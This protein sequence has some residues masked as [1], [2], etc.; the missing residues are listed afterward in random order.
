MFETLSNI[1]RISDLRRRIFYTL[2]ILVVF[3]IGCFI[4]AP[5]I[6]VDLLNFESNNIFGFL[7]VFGGGALENFSIFAMG[8]YPYITAS[9][10]VQLL[11]MDV[12]P[13]FAEWAKQ[14]QEGRRKLAQFT[15]YFTIVLGLIQ[16]FGMT[17]GFNRV[18]PGL[19][20]NPGFGTYLLIVLTLTAG[21]ALLMWMGEQINE[22]GI[23][24]GISIII[25]GGIVAGLPNAA[26]AIYASEFF[27]ASDQWFLNL[28]KVLAILLVV[29]AIIVGVI[30]VQ[31]GIRRIPVQYAKRV[32]GRRMYGGQMTHLPIRVNAAGVI[33]VIFAMALLIF[34]STIASF[35]QGHAVA[36]WII[37]HFNYNRPLG[38]FLYVLLIIGFTYFYTF[39]QIN[40]SQLA[41]NLKKNGGY[42]PGVRPGKATEAYV[43]GVLN[44]ITLTGALFLAAVAILPVFFTAVTNLPQTVQLGG[45]SLLIVVGVA[46]DTMKQID[47][48]LVKRHYKGFIK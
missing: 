41:E 9:I 16:A 18:F 23:G 46:L 47:S 1:F 25:F 37:E 17:I 42:I 15:R 14:G 33:P 40:P 27:G 22:K 6:N 38:M 19:V 13:K 12:V 30:F 35:W 31:Q 7:N 28:V 24:N 32:V 8:V 3:R 21:T 20:E 44:R 4:P 5:N 10:I 36:D 26:R 39:V 48:Q 43:M 29:I 45:T 2:M 34:P 11:A